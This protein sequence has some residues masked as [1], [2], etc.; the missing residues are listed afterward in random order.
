MVTKGFSKEFILQRTDL[1]Q[2]ICKSEKL[3]DNSMLVGCEE[4][5]TVSFEE[6][7][8]GIESALRITHVPIVIL[9]GFTKKSILLAIGKR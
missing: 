5:V 8:N 3:V 9:N 6:I 1:L 2:N 7:C 4:N